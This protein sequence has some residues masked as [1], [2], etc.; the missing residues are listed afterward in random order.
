M[1]SSQYGYEFFLKQRLIHRY[2]FKKQ[3]PKLESSFSQ[4]KNNR[5]Y[6]TLQLRPVLPNKNKTLNIAEINKIYR[7]EK[8]IY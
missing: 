4:K 6:Y 8:Q 1:H 5:I 2:P 7:T 3:N